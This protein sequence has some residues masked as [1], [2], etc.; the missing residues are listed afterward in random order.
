MGTVV[1]GGIAAVDTVAEATAVGAVAAVI[2][3]APEGRS[4]WSVG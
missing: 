2:D 3:Q 4:M 1:M